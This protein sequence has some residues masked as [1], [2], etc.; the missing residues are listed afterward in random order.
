MIPSILMI[1]IEI[2]E[3]N[4]GKRPFEKWLESID[5]QAQKRV[6]IA[7]G[8]LADGNTGSLKSV[9]NGVH[10]I[11]ITFGPAYRIYLCKKGKRIVLLLCGG[12]KTRQNNDIIKAKE[13]WQEYQKEI[14]H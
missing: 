9:G 6:L 13:L 12:T 14:I 7:L 3:T 5:R 11:K 2:Y 4:A 1:E 10:E 8:K